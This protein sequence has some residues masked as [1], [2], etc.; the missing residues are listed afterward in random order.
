MKGGGMSSTDEMI[1]VIC[2]RC[3]EAY[4]HWQR[5][6]MESATSSTC[7]HCG[8][9]PAVDRLIHEDGIWSLTAEEEEPAER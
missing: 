7:P 9:D 6:T 3:G 2:P 8:H 1:E 5:P 4:A